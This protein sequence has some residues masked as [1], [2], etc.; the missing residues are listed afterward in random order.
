LRDHD[1]ETVRGLPG[2]L[3]AGEAILWQGAPL[4]GALTRR[5]FHI[6]LLSI[7]FGILLIWR[8]GSLLWAGEPVIAAVRAASWIA[9]IGAV[10]IGL[11]SLFAWMIG[12]TTI[13]TITNKRIVLRIGVALSID[14]NLPYKIVESAALK[15]YPD[16][17]GD[18]VL[19]MAAGQKILYPALWPHARPWRIFRAQPALRVVPDAAAVAQLLARALA[20]SSTHATAQPGAQAPGA[21]VTEAQPA[22]SQGGAS[23]PQTTAAA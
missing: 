6:E 16:G 18:I 20:E 19:T 5:V 23:R 22:G 10:A 4:W 13:Y 17:T 2:E 8:G 15:S 12:K 9:V 21:P 14:I 3:P 7:Y 1:T 11:L